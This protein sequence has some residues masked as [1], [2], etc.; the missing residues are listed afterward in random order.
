MHPT[1]TPAR[2]RFELELLH[3]GRPLPALALERAD[4]GRAIEATFFDAL[5]GGH[6][7][8]YSPPADVIVEPV[9]ATGSPHAEAFDVAVPLP[10]G[11]EQRRRFGADY[12][13]DVAMR[14]GAQLAVAGQVPPDATLA[15]RLAAYAD[16]A[17]PRK[18]RGLTLQLEE[19]TPAIPI[20][21]RER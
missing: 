2:C 7:S 20:H 5:R 8:E 12:F 11:G 4:F 10:H 1:Q 3:G 13:A 18:K 19:E 16:E 9:S 15:Y 6:F 17:Q 21:V 14:R